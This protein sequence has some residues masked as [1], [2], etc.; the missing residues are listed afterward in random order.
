V[1]FFSVTVSAPSVGLGE[2]TGFGTGTTPRNVAVGDFNRDGKPDLVVSNGVGTVSVLVG[3]GDGTFQ[4]P[5]EY[6]VGHTQPGSRWAISM[7]TAS[8]I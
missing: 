8:S 7:V 6:A 4:P 5:V 1:A 3:N 2:P